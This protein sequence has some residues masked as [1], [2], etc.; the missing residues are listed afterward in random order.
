[1]VAGL[2]G[3]VDVD[4][5]S[6]KYLTAQDVALMQEKVVSLLNDNNQ[7]KSVWKN[8]K[9]GNRGTIIKGKT[10]TRNKL[11]CLNVTFNN[12]FG[13]EKETLKELCVLMT[14]GYGR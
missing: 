3:I 1:M 8:V 7:S 6:A 9:S 10:A 5:R 13:S 14:R 12:H 4:S 2:A 11:Q